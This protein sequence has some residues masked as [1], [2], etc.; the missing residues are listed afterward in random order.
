MADV[1]ISAL[2]AATTPLGGT[3]VLPIVQSGTTKKVSIA[4]VTA[5]RAMSASSLTLSSPL[6]VASGGTGLTSLTAGRIPYGDGTS[7]FGNSANLFFDG[8]NLGV[9]TSTIVQKLTVNNG[10]ISVSDGFGYTFGSSSAYISG[11]SGSNFINFVTSSSEKMRLD[12]AG[13]VGIGTSSPYSRLSA[14]QT[15]PA[16]GINQILTLSN[17]YNVS[18]L[19]EPTI[20]FDNNFSGSYAGWTIGAQVAGGSYFRIC[21]FTGSG[22]TLSEAMRIDASGNV[23]IGAT[24]PLTK[25]DVGGIGRFLQTAAATTGAVIIRA[26]SGN[27][28]AGHLQFVNNDNTAQYGWFSGISGGG[29]AFGSGDSTERMRIDPTGNLLVGTTVPT[30]S[31]FNV[32][33]PATAS[34]APYVAVVYSDTTG[35][36]DYA[37]LLISKYDN[38]TTTSQV[39]LRFAINQNSIANGQINANGASAAAFG[40]W[41][42]ARLKENITPLPSQLSNILALKPSEFDYRDGSGHQI[43]FIAQEMQEVYPDVVG[44]DEDGMLTITGWSKTEARLVKAIQELAAEVAMLK[45]QLNG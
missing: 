23:G 18:G 5:G 7:A 43:G 3:E 31:K 11:N 19:N 44:E 41:S 14:L 25:L 37:P 15:S 13:N 29:L 22:P 27:T 36:L 28:T 12:S 40:S 42:D 35:D 2:P 17:G 24:S 33:G 9:G 10:S 20:R 30:G 39:F 16:S 1:K 34:T 8:T 21:Q 4:D 45:G 26:S 38:N 6:G 32:R